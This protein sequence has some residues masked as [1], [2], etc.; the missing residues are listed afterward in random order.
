MYDLSVQS[1]YTLGRF[2]N[3]EIPPL[4]TAQIVEVT[5]LLGMDE[6][7]GKALYIVVDLLFIGT[8]RVRQGVDPINLDL[9]T[10]F[11]QAGGTVISYSVPIFAK[12]VDVQFLNGSFVDTAFV[13]ITAEA[14]PGK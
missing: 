12:F 5:S 9:V 4:T 13:T 7:R 3:L 10:D 6:I 14:Y 8:I 2:I 11:S 1:S